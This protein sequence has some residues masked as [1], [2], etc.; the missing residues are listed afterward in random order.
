MGGDVYRRTYLDKQA[1]QIE[2]ILF[3]LDLPTKVQ[4]GRVSGEFIRYHLSLAPGM[5]AGEDVYLEEAI[6]EAAGVQDVRVVRE[7]GG[8]AVDISLRQS[9]K[10]RL[11]SL[12]Q[13]MGTLPPMTAV[14]GM[15]QS[16]SPLILDFRKAWSWHLFAF[17]AEGSGKS[18]LLR[19]II[20]SLALITQP[21]QMEVLGIDL[22][23]RELAVLE[24]IPHTSIELATG[25]D[26]STDLIEWLVEEI[27]RRGNTGILHP[28]LTLVIDDLERL[29]AQTDDRVVADLNWIIRYGMT[30][31]V[32]VVAAS[33]TQPLHL[34]LS[35]PGFRGV[36]LA[37]PIG[38][39]HTPGRFLLEG[40]TESTEVKVA[41]LSLHDL[42]LA[43]RWSKV[44]LPSTQ[45]IPRS[46]DVGS[47]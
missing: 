18:E 15:S 16:G 28:H 36:V 39:G 33:G 3:S 35:P 23:G 5:Q 21:T 30:T 37:T 40:A 43:V 34:Q 26:A 1:D 4:G 19:T 17:G 38:V 46:E 42:D 44:G 22:G 41:F 7:N 25:P 8:M 20:L 27:A 47:P 14:V 10:L 9:N 45:G 2:E 29:L 32:H 13:K 12:I 31:G 11:L 24:A 6:A